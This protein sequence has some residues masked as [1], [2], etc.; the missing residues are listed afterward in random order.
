[1]RDGYGEAA[2]TDNM[3]IIVKIIWKMFYFVRSAGKIKKNKR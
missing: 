2:V 1:M 3:I